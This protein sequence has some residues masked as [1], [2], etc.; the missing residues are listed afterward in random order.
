MNRGYST[1]KSQGLK[2]ERVL[3][4]EAWRELEMKAV[5]DHRD[6]AT[7]E[8][9]FPR[10][11]KMRRPIPR[12]NIDTNNR[13]DEEAHDDVEFEEYYEYQFPDDVTKLAGLKL[14]ENAMKWKKAAATGSSVDM[15]NKDETGGDLSGVLGGHGHA[16]NKRKHQDDGDDELHLPPKRPHTEPSQQPKDANEID[17]DI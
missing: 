15:E 1:L 13:E 2:E 8:S 11:I 6:I 17:L 5:L 4:L 7:V 9:K 12:E 14:L 16:L 3:L 10:K